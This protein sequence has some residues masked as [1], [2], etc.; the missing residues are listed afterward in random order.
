MSKAKMV[1]ARMS[2]LQALVALEEVQF[3]EDVERAREA[4]FDFIGGLNQPKEIEAKPR[5]GRKPKR[6]WW[7]EENPNGTSEEGGEAKG[8]GGLGGQT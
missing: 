1:K 4:I 5:R 8:D 7:K 3:F 2:M 6:Q